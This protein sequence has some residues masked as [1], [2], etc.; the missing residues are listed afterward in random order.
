MYTYIVCMYIARCGRLHEHRLAVSQDLQHAAAR[1]CLVWGNDQPTPS[2]T[3]N[4]TNISS[5][6]FHPTALPLCPMRVRPLLIGHVVKIHNSSCSAS[7]AWRWRCTLHTK[8][9]YPPRTWRHH[10][11]YYVCRVREC[12]DQGSRRMANACVCPLTPTA[13]LIVGIIAVR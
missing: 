10:A 2:R 4:H 9:S 11:Y 12:M 13:S 8:A 6:P 1:G 7:P 5:N 3:T